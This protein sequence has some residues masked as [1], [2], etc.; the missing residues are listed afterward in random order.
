M[1]S[2]NIFLMTA[3]MLVVVN[4][5]YCQSAK[6]FNTKKK[7]A[8]G[9]YDPVSYF[10]DEPEE[11]KSAYS[12]SH[13]GVTYLFVSSVNK[14]KFEKAPSKYTPEYGGWCAYAMGAKNEKVKIDPETYK[15]VSGK[16]YLFYNFYFNNTLDSWNKDEPGLKK[17]ADINWEKIIN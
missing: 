9:G 7:I 1:K 6:H 5:S 17:K 4:L 2:K 8:I 14:N 16:L 12:A 11:G 3:L 10:D 15:I 13:E